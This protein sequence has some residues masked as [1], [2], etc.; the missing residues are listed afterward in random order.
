[1][2]VAIVSAIQGYEQ[3]NLRE[4]AKSALAWCR[5][6][7]ERVSVHSAY[8]QRLQRLVKKL[9]CMEG[10]DIR[11]HIFRAEGAAFALGSGDICIFTSMMDKMTDDELMFVV[12]HEIGHIV[13]DDVL[14]KTRTSMLTEAACFLAPFLLARIPFGKAVAAVTVQRTFMQ[15]CLRS[16]GMKILNMAASRVV[17]G[18]SSICYSRKQEYRADL[19]ALRFLHAHGYDTGAAAT[20]LAKLDDDSETSALQRLASSHPDT[21]KRI[22]RLNKIRVVLSA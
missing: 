22:A 4:Q 17:N 5:Q 3:S 14:W 15:R 2:G 13:N 11:Y 16:L 9:Q 21:A 6:N 8:S 10:H 18:V 7:F 19:Y 20:A 1:M 12:A